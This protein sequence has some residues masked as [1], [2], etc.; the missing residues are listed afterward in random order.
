M[1][2][3]LKQRR[4]QA[5]SAKRMAFTSLRAG[6]LTFLVASVALVV[7]LLVDT[8]L[9]IFPRWTLILLIGS[10]PFTLVGVYLLV[11]RSIR[12]GVENQQDNTDEVIGE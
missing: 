8:R 12:R 4:L 1:N 6:C 9:G 3:N 5:Q 11:R 10:A 2:D 7:G